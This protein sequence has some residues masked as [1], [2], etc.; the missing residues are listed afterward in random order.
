A[1]MRPVAELMFFDFFGVCYDMLFNQASKFRYMFGGR[2][3]TPM[4]VRGM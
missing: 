3:K 4:V 2:I 1:G